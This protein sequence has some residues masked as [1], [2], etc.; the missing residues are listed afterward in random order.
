MRTDAATFCRI[1]NKGQIRRRTG[2]SDKVERIDKLIADM[3]RHYER[4]GMTYSEA[5]ILDDMI[6]VFERVRAAVAA[7]ELEIDSCVTRR[8]RRPG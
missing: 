4:G 3:R 6:C 2:M 8:P 5:V 1:S 7:E